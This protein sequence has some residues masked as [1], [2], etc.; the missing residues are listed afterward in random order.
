MNK[1]KELSKNDSVESRRI[2]TEHLRASIMIISDGSRPS[3]IDRGYILR[4]LIRRMTRHMNKLGIDLN[5]LPNLIDLYIE[6]LKEM[7]PELEKKI[8]IQLKK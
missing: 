3:N 8:R 6:T 2:A 4:R 7:Y 5:E 1:L